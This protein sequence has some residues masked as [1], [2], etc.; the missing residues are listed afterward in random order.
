MAALT[1]AGDLAGQEWWDRR[2]LIPP[3]A[4]PAHN[5]QRVLAD[6]FQEDQP[7]GQNPPP[8]SQGAPHAPQLHFP[9]TAP[10]ESLLVRQACLLAS[11][12]AMSLVAL[13]IHTA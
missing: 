6:V 4:S 12:S 2:G 10:P 13:C 11:A 7:S 3:K 1:C 9:K 8:D 5:L